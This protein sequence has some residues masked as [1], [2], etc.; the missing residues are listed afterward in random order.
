LG[1]TVIGLIIA[2][3][4]IIPLFSLGVWWGHKHP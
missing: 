4:A 3:A 2:G 1:G